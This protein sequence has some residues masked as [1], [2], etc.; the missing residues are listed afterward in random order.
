[1][2]EKKLLHNLQET[3]FR[4]DF[5]ISA[6]LSLL[7][8]FRLDSRPTTNFWTYVKKTPQLH[9][10]VDDE[11]C[12]KEQIGEGYHYSSPSLLYLPKKF[13]LFTHPILLLY[14]FVLFRLLGKVWRASLIKGGS[15]AS[16]AGRS[17][18]KLVVKSIQET[19]ANSAHL[20]K[21]REVI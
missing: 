15:T 21:L 20:Q 11:I 17:N 5:R 2:F 10:E 19:P 3:E 16:N 9:W 14:F 6:D 13:D 7:T 4:D 8:E 1:L 18:V 12:L